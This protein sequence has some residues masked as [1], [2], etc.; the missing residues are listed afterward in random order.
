M[1]KEIVCYGLEF[2]IL[3]QTCPDVVSIT[4]LHSQ[5]DLIKNC[6]SE[7]QIAEDLATAANS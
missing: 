2:N 7:C 4:V 6:L 1:Q 5:L 3:L